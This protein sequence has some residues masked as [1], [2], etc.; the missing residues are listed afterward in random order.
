MIVHDCPGL[1]IFPAKVHLGV[2]LAHIILHLCTWLKTVFKKF[3]EYPKKSPKIL[4]SIP[5]Y[6]S[7][8]DVFSAHF[9]YF[10]TAGLAYV[11]VAII[12]GAIALMGI[13]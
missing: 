6:S 3:F 2:P 9:C 13:K 11:I 1:S 4:E 10:N 12:D 5:S 7:K 8:V